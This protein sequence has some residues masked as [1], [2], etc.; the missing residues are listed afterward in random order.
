MFQLEHKCVMFQLEHSAM[1]AAITI[2]YVKSEP[3]ILLLVAEVPK[4]RHLPVDSFELTNACRA[5]IGA[6][7]AKFRAFKSLAFNNLAVT[8]V[9]EKS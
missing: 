9:K 7:C 1:M 6:V 8:T 3:L 2:S 4:Y 5:V